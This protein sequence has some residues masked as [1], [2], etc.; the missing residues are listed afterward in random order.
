MLGVFSRCETLRDSQF[1]RV[2]D[3]CSA[4]ISQRAGARSWCRLA[5]ASCWVLHLPAAPS[6]R[7]SSP[8]QGASRSGPAVQHHGF[9][10][11]V[12][13]GVQLV[14]T[15]CRHRQPAPGCAGS[16][17]AAQ[18]CRPP[19]PSGGRF[20]SRAGQATPLLRGVHRA[21][22]SASRQ[23]GVPPCQDR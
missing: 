10:L 7:P 20:A 6:C 15:A 22:S 2:S 3:Q 18:S 9:G 23:G 1:V 14:A 8:Q 11:I 17:R 4:S 21:G 19:S 5:G 13:P 12:V 16:H